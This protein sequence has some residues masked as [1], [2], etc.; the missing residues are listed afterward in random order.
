MSTNLSESVKLTQMDVDSYERG[1]NVDHTVST[2]LAF[3]SPE[4]LEFLPVT[5]K[6]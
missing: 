3:P 1:H 6:N 5:K 4:T 2:R